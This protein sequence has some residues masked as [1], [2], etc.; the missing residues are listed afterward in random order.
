MD[1]NPYSPPKADVGADG[2]V[3]ESEEPF[4]DLSS[5]TRALSVMLI[6]GAVLIG[7]S[8]LSSLLQLQLLSGSFTPEEGAA[9]DA[10]EQAIAGLLVLFHIATCIVFGRWIY[11][12]HRNLPALG[13]TQLKYR[14]GWAVGS[15][16]VPFVNLLVPYRA[17]RDLIVASESPTQWRFTDAPPWVIVWWLL[18]LATAMMDNYTLRASLGAKSIEQLQN[19]TIVE[20][21]S[22]VTAVPLYFLARLIVQRVWRGQEA[23]SK[24]S[25]APAGFAA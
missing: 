18:W 19:L 12:A 24:G 16:F 8:V 10:R 1:H 4:R 15:F 23:A 25:K 6:V 14:P 13:A 9:N 5:I 21:V 3:S 2:R 20:I 11:L 17:M 7:C 22:G